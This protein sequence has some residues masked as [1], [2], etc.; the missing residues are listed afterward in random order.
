MS[1]VNIIFVFLHHLFYLWYQKKI[2]LFNLEEITF[3]VLSLFWILLL[4]GTL[5]VSFISSHVTICW[6]SISISND[7]VSISLSF[8]FASSISFISLIYCFV[9][10]YA[11]EYLFISSI[12][13]FV[14]VVFLTLTFPMV[15]ENKIWL[16]LFHFG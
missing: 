1:F 5:F 4:V 9:C 6:F 14:Y 12:I 11:F 16:N 3:I 8:S 13:S 7:F 2:C 15:K 10:L